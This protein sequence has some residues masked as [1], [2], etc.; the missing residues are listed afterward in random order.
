MSVT[1]VDAAP[2]TVPVSVSK[3]RTQIRQ[4][5]S[6]IGLGEAAGVLVPLAIFAIMARVSEDAIY[7]RALYV[8]LALLFAALQVG[9]DVSNQV[10]AAVSRGARRPEDVVPVAMSMARIGAVVWGTVAG[11]LIVGAPGLA[12]LLDVPADVTGEFVAF[13]RW[14]CLASLLFFPTVL[15]ASSLRGYGRAR[16][17]AA[18]VLTGAVVEVGGVAL[19]GFTTDLGVYALPIAI[20]AGGACALTVGL[21]QVHR[22]GLWRARGPLTWRR[23]AVWRLTGTGLPVAMSFLLIAVA[24]AGVLWVLAPFGPRV[25]AGYAAA[26][27]LGNLAIVPA[28]ALGSAT[29]IVLNQLRGAGE[30]TLGPLVLRAGMQLTIAV[31]AVVALVVW[32]GRG[33][34]A[35]LL[36]G[37]EPIAAETHRFLTIVGLT[38]LCMGLTVMLLLLVEQI[39]GGLVA[40][41]L[42]IPYFGG[43]VIGGGIIAR[44]L[45][46]ADGLYW[47]MAVLNVS[48][49]LVTPAV[50]W[51]Y[52]RRMG[53]SSPSPAESP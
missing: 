2:P 1:A 22:A 28:S 9:F 23:E 6:A 33:W 51:L 29:A 38:Y 45:D 11:A 13:L 18:I 5:A 50:A 4:I 44:S 3:A 32:L 14:A 47:T 17:A 48:G 40:L 42:N 26:A 46:R 53:R 41:I 27:A 8:P 34:W 35:P 19:L 49:M 24:N 31:Y 37:G 39:G 25:V 16:A 12:A 52:V 20:G 15:C 7:V 21:I 43:M 30:T 10:A 36:A